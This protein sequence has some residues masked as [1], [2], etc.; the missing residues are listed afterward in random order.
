VV[1]QRQKRSRS[2]A[3]PQATA[4]P[5]APS[6][7]D[8]ARQVGKSVS[9]VSGWLKRPDWPFPRRPPWE[10]AKV[11]E[12]ARLALAPNP[13]EVWQQARTDA[14]APTATLAELARLKLQAQVQLAIEKVLAARMSREERAGKLHAVEACRERRIRQIHTVKG[15]LFDLARLLPP[16]VEGQPR[17]EIERILAGRFEDLCRT[18][19]GETAPPPEEGKA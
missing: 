10:V 5:R 18:F 14:A 17:L 1:T 11:R 4:S 19:A 9:T 12:W 2:G 7:R 6:L 16:L 13:A 3:K 8:L 15:A